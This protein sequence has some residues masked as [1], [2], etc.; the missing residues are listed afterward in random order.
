MEEDKKIECKNTN[1]SH[2]I[3]KDRLHLYKGK[4]LFS[5]IICT[6]C[7]I[8][9]FV[10]F[11]LSYS[12]SQD[13]IVKIQKEF[14]DNLTSR[15]LKS[16]TLTKDST[17]SLD[18]VVIDIVEENQKGSL[19]LLE[20]QYNKLQHDFTVLSIWA[21][22]L[23]IVFLIFSI[24]SMFKVDEMQKQGREYLEKMEDTSQKA[25]TI[26]NT[27]TQQSQEKINE[28]DKR[29]KEEM[30]KLSQEYKRQ[31]NDL[32]QEMERLQNEFGETVSKETTEFKKLVQ[33]Y[34][35]K[36][37]ENSIKNEQLISYFVKA[38]GDSSSLKNQD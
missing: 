8:G 17:I 16:L 35:D 1:C 9:I 23:M 3:D 24:Y 27:L 18:K 37:K 11:Q 7:I 36:L 2:Y 38:I 21:G 34:Q 12:N 30:D 15:Y 6:L 14:C 5:I 20:L 4:F 32:K 33:D 25:G 13:K 10:L 22:I 29:A 19:S 28:I 26:S 31:L